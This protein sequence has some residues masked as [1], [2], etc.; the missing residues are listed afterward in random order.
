MRFIGFFNRDGGTFRMLDMPDFCHRAT[1]AFARHGHSLEFVVAGHDTLIEALERAASDPSSGAVLA[2]GGDGTISAAAGICFAAGKPLAVLPAGTMN[3]FARTLRMPLDL[4]EAL[5]AIAGGR[6]YGVDIATANGRPFVNQYSVGLHARLVRI[7]EGLHYRNSLEK[8]FAGIRAVWTAVSKPL[9]FQVDIR[10]EDRPESRI[11]SGI[12]ISNN[13]L[14]EGHLPYADDVDGGVLGV[15]IAK[16]LSPF[17]ALGLLVQ[18]MIGHWKDHARVVERRVSEVTLTF[19]RLKRSAQA[20]V[21]GE[22]IP[23]EERVDLRVLPGALKVVAPVALGEE[24][25]APGAG[26]E[27]DGELAR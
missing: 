21:D 9:R 20:V 18:V 23:L 16:P 6:M 7:R 19:P 14:A 5:E 11:A 22:L 25:G 10:A 2:G 24:T 12:V 15:Y 26:L 13:L 27:A 17:G 1:A 8:R 3:F 4:D